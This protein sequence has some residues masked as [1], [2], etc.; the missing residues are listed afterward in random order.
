MLKITNVI[1]E[2][3]KEKYENIFKGVYNRDIVYFKN[4]TRKRKLKNYKESNN[5]RFKCLNV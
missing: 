3:P 1:R 2:I 5:R 4:K